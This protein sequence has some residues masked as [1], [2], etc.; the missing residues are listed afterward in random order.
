MQGLSQSLTDHSDTAVA[1]CTW[2]AMSE[3]NMAL[4]QVRLDYDSK[5]A[6]L[7]EKLA[8]R[9]GPKTCF[10]EAEKVN[11]QLNGNL[12]RLTVD[13]SQAKEYKKSLLEPFNQAIIIGWSEGVLVDQTEEKAQAI[14]TTA[15]D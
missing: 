15:D 7:A 6:T 9:P 12:E 14:L 10:F 4:Q 13:L 3:D 2:V 11:D 8:K 1:I 5:E